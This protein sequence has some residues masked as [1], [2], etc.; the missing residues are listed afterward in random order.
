M[1]VSL[2]VG[3]CFLTVDFT[4]PA[5]I[6][7][8]ARGM[9]VK[10]E[11]CGSKWHAVV[12]KWGNCWCEESL[13]LKNGDDLLVWRIKP[14]LGYMAMVGF[15]RFGFAGVL[16]RLLPAY[17]PYCR[18]RAPLLLRHL[19]TVTTRMTNLVTSRILPPCSAN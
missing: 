19:L 17:L 2:L 8:T 13:T 5:S 16:G 18:G 7:T 1:S 14:Y 15:D 6:C 11:L 12:G 3:F 4:V 9:V 10:C